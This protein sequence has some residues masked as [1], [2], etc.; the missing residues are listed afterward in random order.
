MIKH[1]A[2]PVLGLA[3]LVG[4]A[5]PAIAE[6]GK[7]Y[8]VK[9]AIQSSQ[10]DRSTK[11]NKPAKSHKRRKFEPNHDFETEAVWR[12]LRPSWFD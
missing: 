4:A 11:Y 3:V 1:L 12:N 9:P 10:A 8:V 7:T 5:A 6:R 2:A